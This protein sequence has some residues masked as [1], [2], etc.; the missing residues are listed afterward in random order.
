MVLVSQLPFSIYIVWG[1]YTGVVKWGDNSY[2]T[3]IMIL[4]VAVLGIVEKYLLEQDYFK[5]Y[6]CLLIFPTLIFVALNSITPTERKHLRWLV[7]A[8]F[9]TECVIAI[10]EH[11]LKVNFFLTEDEVPVDLSEGWLFRSTSILG[12]P[13][14]NAMVVAVMSI[15]I[16][17][18]NSLGM[19]SKAL[20]FVLGF[21]A[22]L[23]FNAR[24]ATLV[25][26]FVTLPLLFREFYKAKGLRSSSIFLLIL[27]LLVAYYLTVNVGIWGGRLLNSDNVFDGSAH[28]RIEVFEFY[29]YL[30]WDQILYGHPDN[31]AYLMN[32]L[33]TGG[34]ENG[35]ISLIIKYGLFFVLFFFPL[36]VMFHLK[37]LTRYY[38]KIDVWAIMIIFYLIGSA[39]PN[40]S[41]PFCWTYWVFSFQAFRPELSNEDSEFSD[42]DGEALTEEHQDS[43]YDEDS[44]AE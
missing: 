13:L 11:N 28:T 18:T 10:V 34:V 14:M 40:L 31:Y 24:A 8:F 26:F 19:V 41:L 5:S 22:I 43:L 37:W 30:N 32:K 25:S 16:V 3:E 17:T 39:N 1:S 20:L 35:E 44:L 4:V 21:F 2:K 27:V 42:N 9:V 6:L 38:S 29:K 36:L 15:F 33:G 23:A 7:L 12:H